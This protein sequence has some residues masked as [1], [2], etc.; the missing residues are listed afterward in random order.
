MIL[1]LGSIYVML[2]PAVPTH[3]DW[4]PGK[5]PNVLDGI[6]MSGKGNGNGNGNSGSF[7]GNGNSGNFNGNGNADSFNGNNQTGNFN[8]NF[9]GHDWNRWIWNL[10]RNGSGDSC[11]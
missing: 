8:G 3:A 11:K 1:L 4:C 9:S 7:N 5:F 10:P 6:D 2:L